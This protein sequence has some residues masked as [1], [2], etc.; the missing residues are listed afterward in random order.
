MTR[1]EGKGVV[2]PLS[3]I[4]VKSLIDLG[5]S[6]DEA[7]TGVAPPPP[8]GIST[9]TYAPSTLEPTEMPTD[10]PLTSNPTNLPTFEPSQSP[11]FNPVSETSSPTLDGIDFG[12]DIDDRPPG[13]I[14]PNQGLLLRHRLLIIFGVLLVLVL[15]ILLLSFFIYKKRY[16]NKQG[17]SNGK[18]KNKLTLHQVSLK[19]LNQITVND[20]K[21]SI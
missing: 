8:T 1:V 20:D 19:D 3:I 14:T 17:R 15:S 21:I 4:S 2:N 6:V 11:N 18:V 10:S 7:T 9:P 16:R 13:E 5:Y 12:D